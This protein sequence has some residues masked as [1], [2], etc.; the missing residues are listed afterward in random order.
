[1]SLMYCEPRWAVCCVLCAVRCG[2]FGSGS[3]WD[4]EMLCRWRGLCVIVCT[5]YRTLLAL[6]AGCEREQPCGITIGPA[7]SC[8]AVLVLVLVLVLG[9]PAPRSQPFT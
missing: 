9:A 7:C 8:P 1:M 5:S 4:D 6:L 3:R 2:R